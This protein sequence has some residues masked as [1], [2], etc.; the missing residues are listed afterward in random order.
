MFYSSLGESLETAN[1]RPLPTATPQLGA[2]TERAANGKFA[3]D[4]TNDGARRFLVE[5]A[6]KARSES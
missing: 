2:K 6:L 4:V 3:F 1:P 5:T